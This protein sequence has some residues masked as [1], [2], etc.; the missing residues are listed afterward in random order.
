[1]RVLLVETVLVRHERSPGPTANPF[2]I[3]QQLRQAGYQHFALY[4]AVPN[5]LNPVYLFPLQP[6]TIRFVMNRYLH[7]KIRPAH[8][9]DWL[10]QCI[11]RWGTSLLPAYGIVAIKK[12]V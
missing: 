4:G 8:G 11:S 3:S 12:N 9:R 1:M 7:K 2:Q 10:A 5:H 6:A